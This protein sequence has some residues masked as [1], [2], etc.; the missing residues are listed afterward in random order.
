MIDHPFSDLD[1]WVTYFSENEI[2]VLRHTA[3][4]L[5]AQR[6]QMDRVTARGLSQI[7]LQD[8]LMVVRVLAYIQPFRSGRLRHDITTVGSAVMMLGIEP[9][10]RNFE[11]L[12]VVE[13]TLRPQ[14]QAM[15]GLLQVIR[16]AQRAAHWAYDWALWRHDVNNEE[17]VIATLLHDLAEILV[18]CFAPTLAMKI[19][20]RQQADHQLR[21][22]VA[23]FEGLGVHLNELQHALCV[24]WQLPDLLLKLM[25][26]EHADHPRV[27]NVILAVNL[28][29]HSANGW[30]D[31]ALPDDYQG[32]ANLLNLNVEAA[33][34]RLGLPPEAL[35]PTPA[36]AG[37]SPS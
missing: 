13:D 37:P 29:R 1:S 2:P 3:R 30:Q 4:Q 15:L 23:Q 26:D 36:P 10:F 22:A 9:F 35:T 32:I 20:A 16:R 21:S 11:N 31:A 18:W 27:R 34:G 28:A 25:D 14:P 24:R 19:R 8:P 5:D 12:A 17:V 6:E 33:K 7:I